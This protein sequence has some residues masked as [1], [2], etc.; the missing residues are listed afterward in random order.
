MFPDLFAAIGTTYGA[1]DGSTTFNLPN[2]SDGKFPE[3]S[4]VAGT[5]K[6]AGLPNIEGTASIRGNG[7]WISLDGT[8]GAFYTSD[9]NHVSYS[10]TGSSGLA[11]YF[12]FDASR[13]NPIYGASN[14]VQPN[15][16]TCRY[17]IKAY[18]GVTPTPAE[19]DIS[20]MLTELT[21]KANRDLDNLSATGEARFAHVVVDSYYDD[22]TGDWYRV[23]ADGWVEQGGVSNGT[24]SGSKTITFLKPFADT[25]YY[26]N[27]ICTNSN[28]WGNPNAAPYSWVLAISG[29]AGSLTTT[30]FEISNDN[31]FRKVWYACGKGAQS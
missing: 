21:G 16:L 14:T 15:A 3:G 30:S 1:G 4:T 20:Q 7:S 25:N 8:N 27:N 12:N 9:T 29:G 18:D 17:I 10:P 24:G 2:Y 23:Y 19:A 22:T 11:G 26:I 31:G 28:S 5:V 6:Q 13:S